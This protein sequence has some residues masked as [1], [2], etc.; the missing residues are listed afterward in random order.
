MCVC[1]GHMFLKNFFFVFND[2]TE[3][4]FVEKDFLKLHPYFLVC[5]WHLSSVTY[6]VIML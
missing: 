3:K 4:I 2:P 5:I 6:Y 1:V